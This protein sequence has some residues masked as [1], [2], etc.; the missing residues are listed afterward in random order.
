MAVV[1]F[2]NAPRDLCDGGRG[3][4]GDKMCKQMFVLE[5]NCELNFVLEYGDDEHDPES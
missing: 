4:G 1:M 2:W 5:L 3:G